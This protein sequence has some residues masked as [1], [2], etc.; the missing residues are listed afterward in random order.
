MKLDIA[1]FAYREERDKGRC[2]FFRWEESRDVHRVELLFAEGEAVPKPGNIRVEYWKHHWPEERVTLADIDKGRIGRLGWKAR[3]DWF[4]GEWHQ[5]DTVA[6][7]RGQAVAIRCAPLGRRENKEL[8]SDYNVRFRQTMQ[9]RIHLP[10]GCGRPE[11]VAVFTDTRLQ[12]RDLT[13]ELGCGQASEPAWDGTI[14]VYNGVC[15]EVRDG[16]HGDPRL[17]LRVACAQPGPLSRDHTVVTLRCSA[18]S[19]SFRPDDLNDGQPIWIPP[20]K[21][22]VR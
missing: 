9:L 19:V 16:G 3:D 18:F 1:P 7:A 11:K 6:R 14:E 15:Q 21:Y 17:H 8:R 10:E 4:N 20:C 2:L 5:A 22:L 13:V 12:T